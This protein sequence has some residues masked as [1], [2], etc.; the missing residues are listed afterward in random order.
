MSA[1]A[2]IMSSGDAVLIDPP[3]PNEHGVYSRED[4]EILV[5][6]HKHAEAQICVLEV[7]D[8]WIS[9]AHYSHKTGSCQ[10][11]AS[12]LTT[13][14]VLPN[15]EAAIKSAATRIINAQDGVISCRGSCTTENQRKQA[16]E[17]IKW[18]VEIMHPTQL[19]FL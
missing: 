1:P 13:Y 19:A 10:G 9:S 7:S 8:G 6:D 17:I 2:T 4:A 5:Y 11:M 14:L 18:C 16:A 12:P 15:R 3:I